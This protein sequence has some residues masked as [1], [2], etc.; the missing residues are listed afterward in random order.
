[1]SIKKKFLVSQI[2]ANND[3]KSTDSKGLGEL[4]QQKETKIMENR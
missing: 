3:P 2:T 4:Q 1:M